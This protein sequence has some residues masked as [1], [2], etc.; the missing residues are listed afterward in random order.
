MSTYSVTASLQLASSFN[1]PLS[2]SPSNTKQCV[3]PVS[4]A[5]LPSLKVAR[6]DMREG[7]VESL[8]VQHG[9]RQALLAI[10]AASSVG[11]WAPLLSPEGASAADIVQRQQRSIFLDGVKEKLKQAVYVR[12]DLIPELLRLALNDAATY[13]KESQSGGANGSIRFA[14][15]LGRPENAGLDAAVTFLE[16]V[17]AE[18]DDGAKGGPISYADLIQLGAQAAAKR[19]FLNAAIGKAGGDE[20][21]GKKLFSAIGSNGQWGYFE[22][23]F[24]RADADKPDPEGRVLVWADAS[25]AELAAKFAPF[26]LKPRQIVALAAFLGRDVEAIEAKLATDPEFAPYVE[27]Y[28]K[29]RL[30]VSETD[31]EVDLINAFAKLSTIGIPINYEAYTYAPIRRKLKL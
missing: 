22:K 8:P 10:G 2:H 15:E 3:K 21:K 6:C 28:R 9:R 1:S 20:V 5:T 19:V 24:G 14:E 26:G 13:N 17:K 27:K 18:I 12:Q 11:V 23:Q 25:P 16:G 31:Y 4:R 30:T 29:S 7:A